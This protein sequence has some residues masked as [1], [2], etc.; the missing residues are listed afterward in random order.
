MLARDTS[1]FVLFR[2]DAAF[3]RSEEPFIFKSPQRWHCRFE[4][5]TFVRILPVKAFLFKE[6]S[7]IGII[8]TFHFG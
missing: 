3:V 1:V 8:G 5:T 4:V 2:A 7:I 6:K